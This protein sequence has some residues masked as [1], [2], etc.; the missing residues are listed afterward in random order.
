[1]A[2]VFQGLTEMKP[3]AIGGYVR[4]KITLE[5]FPSEHLWGDAT[6]VVHR[7]PQG[8]GGEQGNHAPLLVVGQRGAL[9]ATQQSSVKETTCARSLLSWNASDK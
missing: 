9:E 6:G 4:L 5:G 2:H 8:E 3:Q 7:I 1:M